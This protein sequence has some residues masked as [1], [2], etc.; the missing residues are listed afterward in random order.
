[1][2]SI[3]TCNYKSIYNKRTPLILLLLAIVSARCSSGP[4]EPAEMVRSGISIGAAASSSTGASYA[5][6]FV[7]NDDKLRRL[8][9]Y[10]RVRIQN[11]KV[12][13]VTTGGKKII[14]VIVNSGKDREDWISIDSYA[15]L[16]KV[17][18]DIR[19]DD[20]FAPLMSG[21]ATVAGRDNEC[22]MDMQPL[23]SRVTLRSI[24]CDF[25]GK[26]YEDEPLTEGK[27]YLTNVNAFCGIMDGSGA[28]IIET[29]N[30]AGLNPSDVASLQSPGMLSAKLPTSI[31]WKG[32]RTDI[33]LYCYPNTCEEETLGTRFT[34]LV[35]EGKIRGIT[36]YWPIDINREDFG[37]VQ[38]EMPGVARNSTYIFDVT[39]TRTGS[40]DPDV[41][42]SPADVRLNCSIVPWKEMSDRVE[43]Y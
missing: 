24:S 36:Y 31:G 7:F 28:T 27:V 13:A 32:V 4:A 41:P 10:Q 39:L 18:S 22:T 30:T 9:T 12:N 15:A 23:M 17:R 25:L 42:V 38:G 3:G 16:Q 37:P 19:N 40:F 6:V 33:D 8:D 34:R 43:Q 2:W 20:P 35:I 1:M 5:D 14:A 21:S 11:G 26:A 29:V